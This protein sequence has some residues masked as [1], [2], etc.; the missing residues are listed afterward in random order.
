MKKKINDKWQSKQLRS[1]LAEVL[2]TVPFNRLS[3]RWPDVLN[4]AMDTRVYQ[5]M[6]RHDTH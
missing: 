2:N 1:N 3:S 6:L 4:Y 5:P